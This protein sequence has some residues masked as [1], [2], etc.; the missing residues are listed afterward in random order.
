M[1]DLHMHTNNS[2]GS[3]TTEELIK[4]AEDMKLK[5]ISITD[6]DN[7][8]AHE[9]I[10]EE[11]L[12]K[13]FSGKII[14]GIEIKCIYKKRTIEVL[15][16]KYD[17]DKMSAWV[18]DF[19]KDKSKEVLQKKYFNKTYDACK[20][21][22]FKLT[23]KDK[24]DWNP[25]TDWASFTIYSDLKKYKENEGV[26]ADDILNDFTT[27]NKK[28]CGDINIMA[29]DKYES[30]L[31]CTERDIKL[32]ELGFD[33]RP[34][35][36]ANHDRM[37]SPL[38]QEL[39]EI[40]KRGLSTRISVFT[41]GCKS[42]IHPHLAWSTGDNKYQNAHEAIIS[43][44]AKERKILFQKPQEYLQRIS[45]AKQSISLMITEKRLRNNY[46]EGLDQLE[47][48]FVNELAFER[49]A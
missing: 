30:F 8:H 42:S 43:E 3:D 39:I 38:L 32:M 25:K 14:T 15:G 18:K 36:R 45:D 44:R 26:Y 47:A 1:I 41:R 7:L 13:L 31:A 48:E 46:L 28:Y 19:Y 9:E 5:Y 10:R 24:I 11:H 4:N 37:Y 6:H 33:P 35:A 23:E 12:E 17:L 2:D 21:L 34:V 40:Q 29:V 49:N 22:G 20:Q 16:Y 27:F